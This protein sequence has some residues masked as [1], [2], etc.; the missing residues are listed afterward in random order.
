MHPERM[1][2]KVD[3]EGKMP[4]KNEK[5]IFPACNVKLFRVKAQ[6]L[7]FGKW[8]TIPEFNSYFIRSERMERKVHFSEI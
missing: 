8:N 6:G 5:A 2:D 4:K 1:K 3:S 7:K